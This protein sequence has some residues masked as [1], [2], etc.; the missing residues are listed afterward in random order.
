MFLAIDNVWNEDIS[1][2]QAEALL[3]MG[4]HPESLVIV[5]SRNGELLKWLGI[6]K[7]C[8]F[9]MPE[10]DKGDATEILLQSAAPGCDIRSLTDYQRIVVDKVV[11]RCFLTK[12]PITDASFEKQYVPLALEAMGRQLR[13]P[14]NDTPTGLTT[15]VNKLDLRRSN[16]KQHPIFNVLRL[17]YDSLPSSKHKSIFLD[18][19]LCAPR[20]QDN[21]SPSV[22]KVCEWLSMVYCED[23]AVI[24]EHVST[25]FAFTFIN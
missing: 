6:H 25:L 5:T 11:E 13:L 9:E 22:E 20:Q 18:I 21:N 12:G 1:R 3:G 24:C 8:C 17:S 15:W 7:E 4:F 14:L 2:E 16:E 10:L 19:A 23:S